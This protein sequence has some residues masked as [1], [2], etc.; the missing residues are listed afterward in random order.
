MVGEALLRIGMG[1]SGGF[2]GLHL[3]YGSSRGLPVFHLDDGGTGTA[4]IRARLT[5]GDDLGG[6]RLETGAGVA[7]TDA[8]ACAESPFVEEIDQNV[9]PEDANREKDNQGH[10]CSRPP[11]ES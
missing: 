2:T 10:F 6:R 3:D 4:N 1:R 8:F 7:L 11:A 5:V 9:N